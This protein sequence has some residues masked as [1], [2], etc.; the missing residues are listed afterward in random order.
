MGRYGIKESAAIAANPYRG[1][2]WYRWKVSELV[3]KNKLSSLDTGSIAMEIARNC[4]EIVIIERWVHR[5][6]VAKCRG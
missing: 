6:L 3:V 1:I 5:F 4:N 2:E